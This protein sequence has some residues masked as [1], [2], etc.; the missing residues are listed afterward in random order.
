MR[1]ADEIPDREDRDQHAKARRHDVAWW[2]SELCSDAKDVP[3]RSGHGRCWELPLNLL[4]MSCARTI[5]CRKGNA[6]TSLTCGY[7]SL[8]MNKES[9]E[10]R[11]SEKSFLSPLKHCTRNAWSTHIRSPYR[12]RRN[13]HAGQPQN[14]FKSRC[15]RYRNR[16]GRVGWECMP[17]CV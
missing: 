14:H 4:K 15:G 6:C 3:S 11:G 5:S 1:H 9:T 8:S 17:G 7:H 16:N 12:L 2:G 10:A 13:Q